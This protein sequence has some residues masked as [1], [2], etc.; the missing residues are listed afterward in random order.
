MCL[1]LKPNMT[2]GIETSL[3]SYSHLHQSCFLEKVEVSSQL[4]V[5]THVHYFPRKAQEA[6][7][8]NGQK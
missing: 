2:Q 3:C 1:H 6:I 5:S 4:D 8:I 7:D